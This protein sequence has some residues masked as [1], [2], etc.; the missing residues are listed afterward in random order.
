[1]LSNIDIGRL[2]KK[3][4]QRQHTL[5]FRQKLEE[6][7]HLRQETRSILHNCDDSRRS[8][9]RR[10]LAIELE[11]GFNNQKDTIH[12]EYQPKLN[13]QSEVIGAEA[14]LRWNHP[15]CGAIS[16]ELILGICEE[17]G[18]TKQ[19]TA[20]ILNQA[21][22]DLKQWHIQGHSNL[23]ISINVDPRQLEEEDHLV[24]TIQV[25]INK[26]TIDPKY[27][28]LE[29]TERTVIPQSRSVRRNLEK[30]KAMDINVSIDD[31]GM[32][33]SSLS[34]LCEYS[35]SCVKLDIALVREIE[36]CKK[37]Q[38]LVESIISLCK[39]LNVMVVAE[40]VETKQQLE[41]LQKLG[42]CYYQGF[43]FSKSLTSENFTKFM[44]H[45][46]GL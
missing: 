5:I 46:I 26:A 44:T 34:Y 45:Q 32:G 17:A 36:S 24:Q 4:R 15:V 13:G 41:I 14:L 16:P 37:R 38:I 2:K 40:G 42:C 11:Y 20:W 12:L 25:C 43:Y 30:L 23:T 19:L 39:K 7:R 31:F 27:V 8:F 35:I 22:S 28:E 1:M 29:L 33:H 10:A 9:F 3:Y 6:I 18:L 21:I